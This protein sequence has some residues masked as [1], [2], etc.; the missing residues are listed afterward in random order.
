MN[1]VLVVSPHPDDES[2]GCGGTLCIRVLQGDTV[3]VLF[4]TSGE[5]GGHGRPPTEAGPLREREAEI[6][7]AVF[8]L[9]K[10]EFWRLPDGGLRA[11][12]ALTARLTDVIRQWRSDVLYVPHEEEMNADHRAAANGQA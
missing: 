3:R 9:Q 12:K 11:T 1:R 6:A 5:N 7:C 4:L 2:V 10:F 8:G